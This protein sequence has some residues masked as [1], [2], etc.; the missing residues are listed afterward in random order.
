MEKVR[1]ATDAWVDDKIRDETAEER[2]SLDKRQ[3]GEGGA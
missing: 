3:L 1:K 2:R